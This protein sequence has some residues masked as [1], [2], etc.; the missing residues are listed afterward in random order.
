MLATFDMTYDACAQKLKVVMN[1]GSDLVSDPYSRFAYCSGQPFQQWYAQLPAYCREHAG[2]ENYTVRFEAPEMLALLAEHAF[3]GHSFQRVAPRSPITSEKRLRWA[4]ELILAGRVNPTASIGVSFASGPLCESLGNRGSLRLYGCYEVQ[5]RRVNTESAQVVL[6]SDADAFYSAPQVGALRA[7]LVPEGDTSRLKACR[8]SNLLFAVGA[9]QLESWLG[10]WYMSM[11]MPQDLAALSRQLSGINQWNV[12]DRELYVEKRRMLTEDTPYLKL[13]APSRLEVGDLSGR[14]KLV[15]LPEDMPC[16]VSAKDS[17]L[18]LLSADGKI[19]P[20]QPGTLRLTA[21][22]ASDPGHTV[23]CTCTIFKRKP[24]TRI[25]LIAPSQQIV[26]GDD[27]P[28]R[29]T[30]DPSNADN[31]SHAR[32]SVSPAGALSVDPHRPGYFV[33]RRAGQCTVTLTIDSVSAQLTLQV[34][35][36]AQKVRLAS[37]RMAVKITNN[38]A[39][40]DASIEPQGAAGASLRYVVYDGRVLDVAQA[41][42][43]IRPL[44]EGSTDVTVELIDRHSRVLD[45]KVCQVEIVPPKPVYN[46]DPLF[47]ISIILAFLTFLLNRT[48]LAIVPALASCVLAAVSIFK[49]GQPSLQWFFHVGIALLALFL[50]QSRF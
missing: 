11:Q 34:Y 1:G 4:S 33:A 43:A 19:K 23:S 3:S 2:T 9:S 6:C 18:A 25:T 7:F 36:A 24:V 28:V 40:I 29:Y 8:G 44:A 42:G 21:A 50:S 26:E 16:L 12:A 14:F 20:V 22:P 35:P 30:Y 5:I 45:S 17:R 41:N 47:V 46:P 15:K 31:L 49:K 13:T 48:S 37:K 10:D 32:W 39:M 38:S 27:F